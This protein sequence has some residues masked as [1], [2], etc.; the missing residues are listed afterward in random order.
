MKKHYAQQRAEFGHDMF[1]EFASESIKL[2]IDKKGVVTED[3]IW[4]IIPLTYPAEV[5][6]SV[7]N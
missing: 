1:I 4:Q 7:C 5:Y 3:Q 2:R 6:I